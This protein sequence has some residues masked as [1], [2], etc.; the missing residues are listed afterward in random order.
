MGK[1]ANFQQQ[2][3]SMISPLSSPHCFLFSLKVSAHLYPSAEIQNWVST[4]GRGGEGLVHSLETH[5][6]KKWEAWSVCR[7]PSTG[8]PH[9]MF[10][11]EN[12][13]LPIE[14]RET[15][16]FS[17]AVS[18]STPGSSGQAEGWLLSYSSPLSSQWVGP[19][20][21]GPATCYRLPPSSGNIIRP[22]R[23]KA[24][25]QDFALEFYCRA[26]LA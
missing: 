13:L 4:A 24:E 8:H 23:W 18:F 9:T 1:V 3:A 17:S 15:Q 14:K 21:T 25:E 5:P 22:F 26:Y 19:R 2:M 7:A 12:C 10:T 6:W 11:E 20:G 16:L